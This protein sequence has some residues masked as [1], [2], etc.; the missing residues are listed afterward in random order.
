[1]CEELL[2]CAMLNIGGEGRWGL[3]ES[4]KMAYQNPT[5]PNSHPFDDKHHD[6]YPRDGIHTISRLLGP[7]ARTKGTVS[8]ALVHIMHPGRR[9]T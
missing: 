1:M 2:Q 8:H 3:H 6:A 5:K 9:E 4:E 7:G